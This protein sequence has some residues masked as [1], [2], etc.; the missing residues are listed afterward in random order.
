MRICG[1]TGSSP[2]VRGTRAGIAAAPLSRTVHP[3]AC[4][5]HFPVAVAT[6]GLAGSS[7]RVRGT[8][9][10]P[11][12][13]RLHGAVHPRACG[14][15]DCVG[16]CAHCVA[17]GSSPRVRGTLSDL[18]ASCD[19]R[20]IPARAGNTLYD[21]SPVTYPAVHPR[22]C[23]EHSCIRCPDMTANGSSPRVRGTRYESVY[24]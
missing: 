11:I 1:L 23:G 13:K 15:H 17:V 22:A 20:F 2:R 8:P 18:R 7:P 14:E 16:A 12:T 6:P 21:V 24:G 10:T 5:E 4:G 9:A 3:R 19:S